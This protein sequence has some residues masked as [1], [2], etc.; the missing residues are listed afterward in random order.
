MVIDVNKKQGLH[1]AR[2][3]PVN[4]TVINDILIIILALLHYLLK[5]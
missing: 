3:L 5:S 1:F 4:F 2:D